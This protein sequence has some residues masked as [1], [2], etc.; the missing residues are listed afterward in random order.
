MAGQW[1][2]SPSPSNFH[3]FLCACVACSSLGNHTNGAEIVLPS[4]RSTIS[5][6]AVTRTSF[7]LPTAATIEVLIMSK[8]TRTLAS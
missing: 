3:L 7:A 8:N 6:W 2:P 4:V 1:I 5:S